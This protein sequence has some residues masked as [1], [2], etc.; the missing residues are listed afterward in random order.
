MSIHFQETRDVDPPTEYDGL[1][2]EMQADLQTWIAEMFQ[3]AGRI[4]R[5]QIRTSRFD[6]TTSYGLKHDFERVTGKYVTNGEFKGAMLAAGYQPVVPHE[7]NWHFRLRP[8]LT[9]EEQKPYGQFT[10]WLRRQKK[11]DDPIGDLSRDVRADE[12][13]PRVGGYWEYLRYL[14]SQH[15]SDGARDAFDRAW[16]EYKRDQ[17]ISVTVNWRKIEEGA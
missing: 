9:E 7:Q 16:T 13:W 1:S 17:G 10:A 3:P 15:A 2:A 4:W 11:R 6:G 14:V 8:R 12:M 5:G